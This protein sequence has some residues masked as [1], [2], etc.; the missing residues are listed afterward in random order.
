MISLAEYLVLL[1]SYYHKV[2]DSNFFKDN[3]FEGLVII[4]ARN[5]RRENPNFDEAFISFA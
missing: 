5:D 3:F 1:L 2:R 4:V